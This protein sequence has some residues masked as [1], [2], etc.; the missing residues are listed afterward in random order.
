MLRFVRHTLVISIPWTLAACGDGSSPEATDTTHSTS[1]T[2]TSTGDGD[3]STISADGLT[4]ASDASDAETMDDESTDTGEPVTDPL[5][6]LDPGPHL[7]MIVG[8]ELPSPGTEAT[9]QAHW[10]DA[11]DAGMDIGRL[12][13]DW[14]ELEPE[15]GV[16]ALDELDQALQDLEDDGLQIMVTL[17]T[18]DSLE[19]TMPDDLVDP[20][21]PLALADGMAF[22]DPIVTQRFAALL[23]AVIPVVV[24]HGGFLVT[25][26]NEPDNHFEDDPD[27][28]AEVAGFT[29]A[30]RQHAANVDPTLAISMTLTYASVDTYEVS[31][32]ILEVVDVATFNFYC[33][34]EGREMAST[35]AARLNAMLEVADDKPIVIQE[36]GCHAGWE[37]M[38][39]GLGT[40]TEIQAAFFG[41]VGEHMLTESRLRAAYVF[42]LLDWSPA[43]TDLFAE[44]LIAAGFGPDVV[45]MF[46]E[47]LATIGL[48]RWSDA[49]C[50]PAWDVVLD[51]LGD[52]EMQQ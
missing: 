50:R 49:T 14:S 2:S 47:S 28:A 41:A 10:D 52:F 26:G 21:Q 38:P 46:T 12:Q 31:S 18:I 32:Q 34:G 39:S 45:D 35:V 36:L 4:D 42:Q 30:A 15:P 25:V 27:F 44:E 17:S 1:S 48:C 22:D 43:L 7:G 13:V 23:D 37:D 33:E 51:V 19:Y 20:E 11:L 24:D 3:G 16:F 29:A 6:R 40:S 9:V 5:S 8:F